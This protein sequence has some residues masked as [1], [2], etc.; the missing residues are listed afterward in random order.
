LLRPSASQAQSQLAEALR[1][2]GTPTFIVGK[3]I[4]WGVPDSATMKRLI[5]TAPKV[6][7]DVSRLRRV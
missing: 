7:A 4:L 2:S 6:G 5:A 3:E 1:I